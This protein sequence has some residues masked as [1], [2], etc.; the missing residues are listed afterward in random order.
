[1]KHYIKKKFD[2][3]G[4]EG[5]KS[6]HQVINP[7][8]IRDAKQA[9]GKTKLYTYGDRATGDLGAEDCYNLWMDGPKNFLSYFENN[10]KCNYDDL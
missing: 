9:G 2:A 7:K 10:F 4:D 3:D 8:S 5:D 6:S 1:M